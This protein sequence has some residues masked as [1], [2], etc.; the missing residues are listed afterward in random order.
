MT[1]TRTIGTTTD[2][3]FF[4]I[5]NKDKEKNT[6]QPEHHQ[7]G[8]PRQKQSKQGIKRLG[9]EEQPGQEIGRLG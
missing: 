4:W 1:R 7:R 5:I 9:Q 6:G 8:Q 2:T 3:F